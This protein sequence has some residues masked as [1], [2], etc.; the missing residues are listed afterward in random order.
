[1]Y[2]L[3]IS[4]S[5]DATFDQECLRLGEDYM[6]HI[7]HT[8]AGTPCQ[9]W[10]DKWPHSHAYDDITY[11]ADYRNSSSAIIHDVA[12]YCRNPSMSSRSDDAQPWCFTTNENIEREFCDIP[13]CKC[14]HVIHD[15][16]TE[17]S[18]VTSYFSFVVLRHL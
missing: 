8:T 17:N 1:M 9:R 7:N 14:K 6:G 16:I 3:E 4:E 11:F 13:R 12:N 2:L 5:T 10:N 18:T 15:S